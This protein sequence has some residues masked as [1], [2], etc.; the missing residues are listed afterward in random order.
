MTDAPVG[1][2]VHFA[3][4][5]VV[6]TL[7]GITATNNEKFEA[8]GGGVADAL[9]RLS[10]TV[11]ATLTIAQKGRA[12]KIGENRLTVQVWSK[13]YTMLNTV[14]EVFGGNYYRH[15]SGFIWACSKRSQLM[16]VW[17]GV[18]DHVEGNNL[19]SLEEMYELLRQSEH[20][21]EVQTP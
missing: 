7:E 17:K 8:K 16:N 9:I 13:D 3:G 2:V 5:Q 20:E 10:K 12:Y 21:T 6:R 14:K 4:V 1:T 18:K 19:A 15:G 11:D